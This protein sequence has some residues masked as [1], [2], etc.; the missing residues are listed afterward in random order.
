MLNCFSHVWLFATLWSVAH[1]V[2][3]SMEFSRQE[4]WSGLP[5]PPLDLPNPGIK[6]SLPS[7]ALAGEFFTTSTTCE[8]H[9]YYYCYLKNILILKGNIILCYICNNQI[10][11]VCAQSFNCVL[12]FATPWTVARQAPLSMGFSRQ[13]C[14]S[15]WIEPTSPVSLALQVNFLPAEPLGKPTYNS[16]CNN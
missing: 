10:S 13:E 8:A 1:Q 16:D 9:I 11:C 2:P 5:C 6:P 3:L 7:P 15:G 14:W 4:Y 12:L